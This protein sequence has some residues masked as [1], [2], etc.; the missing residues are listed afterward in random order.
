[1]P[2]V[3]PEDK[4]FEDGDF[5]NVSD[6]LQELVKRNDKGL[7]MDRLPK[8]RPFSCML[9]SWTITSFNTKVSR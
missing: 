8:D 7:T 1:M 3:F 2:E 9:S 4:L 5:P 6:M